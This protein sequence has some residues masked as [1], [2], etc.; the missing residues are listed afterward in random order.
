VARR[1][2]VTGG[3]GFLGT[4]L[5]DHYL[6]RPGTAVLSYD[7]REPRCPEHRA[8][9]RKGDVRETGRLADVLAEFRPT[10]LVHLAGTTSQSGRS[11]AD[12]ASNTDGVTAVLDGTRAYGGLE[13]SVFA[14]SRLVCDLGV[15]PSCDEDYAPPNLYGRSKVI[16]E[17]RVRAHADGEWVIVRPTSIWGP[18]GDAPYRQFFLSLARGRYVQPSSRTPVRKHYGYVGNTVFQLDRLLTLPAEQ[19]HGRTLYLADPEPV[20]VAQLAVDIRAAMGLPPPRTVPAALLG[21]VA[22]GFDL[23]QSAGLSD[24]PL[25]SARLAHLRTDMLFELGELDR[26]VGPL[27]YTTREGIA[28]TVAHLRDRG[29]LPATAQ[30]VP[31]QPR[32]RTANVFCSPARSAGRRRAPRWWDQ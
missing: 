31:V 14:S 27:P 20:D 22:R 7:S 12:Y 32:P 23:A 16:G 26:L 13:R 4:N 29:D 24:P 9:W 3:S 2:L 30:P 21:L 18:W 19:V 11:M 6:S 10:H 25:T 5:L 1:V 17:Q 28:L 15:Q 8:R